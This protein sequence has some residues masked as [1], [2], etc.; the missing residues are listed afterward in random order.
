M[1]DKQLGQDNRGRFTKG[2]VAHKASAEVRKKNKDIKAYCQ[3][4]S[5]R[6]VKAIMAVVTDPRASPAERIK[7]AQYIIDR[8]YGKPETAGTNAQ[9]LFAGATI[10]VDTGIKREPIDVTTSSVNGA[11]A[12]AITGKDKQ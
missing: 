5:M 6:A 2:N 11:A 7:G 10:M 12:R 1:T 9:G 3:R 4:N 8:G